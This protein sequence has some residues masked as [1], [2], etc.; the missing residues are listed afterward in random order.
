[1]AS[2]C[3]C[4]PRW[5]LPLPCPGR[6]PAGVAPSCL[7]CCC[8]PPGL[9]TSRPALLA[10]RVEVLALHRPAHAGLAGR[11]PCNALAELLPAWP[12]RAWARG[13]MPHWLRPS[14]PRR[15]PIG[16]RPWP[17]IALPMP[18]SLAAA[19]AVP[20]PC[21]CRRGP[22]VPGL[23]LHAARVEAQPGSAAAVPVAPRSGRSGRGPGPASP[24][25]WPHRWPRPV[26]CPGRADPQRGR[27][28]PPICNKLKRTAGNLSSKRRTAT[29]LQAV[30]TQGMK[31]AEGLFKANFCQANRSP[32]EPACEKKQVFEPAFYFYAHANQAAKTTKRHSSCIYLSSTH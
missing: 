16:S 11:C 4:R 19:P 31:P 22:V 32:P 17:C 5:P 15:W 28:T 25:Q 24:R 6:A 8:M 10:D 13:C 26:P 29:P 20:W 3:P 7:A 30:D 27:S 2:P 23:L 21:P 18:A 12:R 14:R 9:R 1:P